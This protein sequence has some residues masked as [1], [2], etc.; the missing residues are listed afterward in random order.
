[1]NT[2][3][4]TA[5]DRGCHNYSTAR[6]IYKWYQIGTTIFYKDEVASHFEKKSDGIGY[7]QLRLTLERSRVELDTYTGTVR[8]FTDGDASALIISD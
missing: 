2:V 7:V 3:A 5:R 1:M 6:V 4:I 8:D